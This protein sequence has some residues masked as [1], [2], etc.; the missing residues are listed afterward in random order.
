MTRTKHK[1]EASVTSSD[2]LDDAK[3]L[4][5]K[6]TAL[7]GPAPALT[8]ADVRRSTKLRKGGEKVIPTLTT[9]SEQ[10]G[11]VVPS[12]P[13]DTMKQKMDLA[14]SLV[15]LH[16]L[17]VVLTKQ[18]SDVLFL[19]QSDS[20]DAATVHYAVLRR[21]AQKNGDIARALAP[22]TQFFAARSAAVT[23]EE[24][25]KRG[26]ARKGSK[27]KVTSSDA[28]GPNANAPTQPVAAPAPTAA[29]APASPTAPSSPTTVTNAPAHA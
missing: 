23:A 27:K 17:L 26:G 14:E 11:I 1:A 12:H 8:L 24:K 29:A 6:V 10:A 15:P 21:L 20:W 2:L 3:A 4:A 28:P 9:L 16:K 18:I 5:A 22:V 7:V 13:T 25:A 19:A